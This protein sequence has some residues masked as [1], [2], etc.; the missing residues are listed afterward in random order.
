MSTQRRHRNTIGGLF[1]NVDPDEQ[2]RADRPPEVIR[3]PEPVFYRD[4]L[5]GRDPSWTDQLTLTQWYM[6]GA[7]GIIL[8]A[9]LVRK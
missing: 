8:I 9:W 7:A 4:M 3:Q 2:P 5:T 1:R 6:L